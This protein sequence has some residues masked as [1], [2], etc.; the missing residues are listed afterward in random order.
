LR[1]N[2][3]IA[4]P[5][6]IDFEIIRSII[7]KRGETINMDVNKK[8]PNIK[9]GIKLFKKYL[10]SILN[11]KGLSKITIVAPSPPSTGDAK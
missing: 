11:Y 3:F 10:F 1:I 2:N 5:I 7:S 4:I 9:T 6:S 8:I